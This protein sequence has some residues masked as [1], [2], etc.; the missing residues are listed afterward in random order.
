MSFFGCAWNADRLTGTPPVDQGFFAFLEC[1]RINTQATDGC[2]A[3]D[4]IST[5]VKDREKI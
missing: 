5:K 2:Q 3:R 4:C 1:N